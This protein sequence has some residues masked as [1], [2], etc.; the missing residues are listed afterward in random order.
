MML[1]I[2][3]IIMITWA[4]PHSNAPAD[5]LESTEVSISEPAAEDRTMENIRYLF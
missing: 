2:A 1:G 4:I 3:E 5:G